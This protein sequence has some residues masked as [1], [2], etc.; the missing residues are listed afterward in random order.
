MIDKTP[1]E[2]D[3]Q[4]LNSYNVAQLQFAFQDGKTPAIDSLAFDV[5]ALDDISPS[6]SP[7]LVR[8][9]E[10]EIDYADRRMSSSATSD[11][12]LQSHP[13]H[14]RRPSSPAH[15]PLPH[16]LP[17]PGAID[18][19][20]WSHP[21]TPSPHPRADDPDGP[22]V[23]LPSLA[24]TFH[25]RHELRRASLPTLYSD[26]PAS[27]LRLPHPAHRPSISSSGLAA[28]QFPSP[29]AYSNGADYPAL[30]SASPLAFSPLAPDADHWAPGIVRPSSTPGHAAGPPKYDDALRHA[31]LGGPVPEQHLFG[32]VT[33]ISGQHARASIKAEGEQWTFPAAAAADYTMSPPSYPST[34][35]TSA[36]GMPA[37]APGPGPG[38]ADSPTR[39]PQAQAAS[40]LVERP[41]RKRG[42]L[43]KPVTDFLKDWL[44]RHS[45]HPY[46]SEEEK[47]QLCHATGLSMSQVSNW[48]INAR[49]RILAPA[50]RAAA[51]PTT[52]TPFS[53]RTPGPSSVLDTGRR[54]SMPTDG[55]QLY[56]PMSL[57]SLEP[58]PMSSS[59]RYMV[60]MT[61]S[62]SSSHATAGALSAHAHHAHGH[63]HS[64]YALDAPYSQSRLGYSGGGGGGGS[65]S[66]ALH[67]HAQSGGAGQSHS[68]LGGGGGGG[69]GYL[70]VPLSAGPALGGQPAYLGAQPHAQQAMYGQGGAYV[71]SPHGGARMLAPDDAP[72]ARYTFPEHA[73]SPQ[74]GSGYATPQ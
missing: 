33:R 34:P 65:G 26:S 39:S 1:A 5:H 72:P 25:D 24:S 36:A 4:P 12:S 19:A 58:S 7:A 10:Q 62:L 22:R 23:Q 59:T 13:D 55:L 41:P 46:P 63:A 8:P 48:M 49:R 67:P 73:A 20:P 14:R 69:G 27:R 2:C 40:S 66:G 29:D 71:P 61:R 45:D 53:A 18:P 11:S 70:G 44:H 6:A 32:G 54:A 50:H 43:P 56:H 17:P 3:R 38:P 47:K 42:K 31:S 9:S 16:K 28:Y 15:S 52:T 68:Q 60:G 35:S 21:N 74:P 64:P 51:G 57:Q 37:A 30:S